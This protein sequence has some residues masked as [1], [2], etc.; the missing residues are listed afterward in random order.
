MEGRYVTVLR[1]LSN[2]T[3]STLE[4]KEFSRQITM[5][6][7]A[8]DSLKEAGYLLDKRTGRLGEVSNHH[9]Y[10]VKEWVDKI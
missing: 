3:E 1:G 9:N 6:Q 4:K 5:A 7:V 2:I 8:V 10:S